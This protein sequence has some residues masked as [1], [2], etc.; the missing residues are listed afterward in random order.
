MADDLPDEALRRHHEVA[1]RLA[2]VEAALAS[3]AGSDA[4]RERVKKSLLVLREV[5]KEQLETFIAADGL[6]DRIVAADPAQSPRIDQL[7]DRVPALQQE[8]RATLAAIEHGTPDEVRE[9][10]IPL[11]IDVVRLRQQSADLLFE[12]YWHDIGGPG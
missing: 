7:R 5:G 3:P 10:S 4:W 12:T 6:L 2:E 9:T 8:M 11:L 1:D